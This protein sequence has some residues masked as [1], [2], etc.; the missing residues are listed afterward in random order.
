MSLLQYDSKDVKLKPSVEMEDLIKMAD[1]AAKKDI[2]RESRQY[3]EF[4]AIADIVRQKFRIARRH[5]ESEFVG[6]RSIETLLGQAEEQYHSIVPLAGGCETTEFATPDGVISVA[7][8]STA[9]LRQIEKFGQIDVKVS[10]TKDFVDVVTAMLYDSY[11]GESKVIEYFGTPVPTI[12]EKAREL[13]K[14]QMMQAI[15]VEE[16]LDSTQPFTDLV[17]MR[18]MA[19][20]KL[21][22]HMQEYADMVAE[23]HTLLTHDQMIEGGFMGEFSRFIFNFVLYPYAVM[24]GPIPE[25]A[26][27]VSWDGERLKT[28]YKPKMKF[29]NIHP[30]NYYWSPDTREAGTGEYDIIVDSISR[31]DLVKYSEMAKDNKGGFIKSAIDII[32]RETAEFRMSDG[33]S[34]KLPYADWFMAMEESSDKDTRYFDDTDRCTLVKFYGAFLGRDLWELGSD[35]FDEVRMEEYYEAEVWVCAGRTIWVG[36][37]VNKATR[38]RPIFAANYQEVQSGIAGYGLA[39]VLTDLERCRTMLLRAAMLHATYLAGP[40]GEYDFNRLDDTEDTVVTLEPLTLTPVRSDVGITT[41]SAVRFWSMPNNMVQLV[42][43]IGT[44]RNEAHTRTGISP[45]V[46]G[47]IQGS[48][49]RSY[50]GLTARLAQGMK[51]IKRSALALEQRVMVPMGR[52]MYWMNT[53]NAAEYEEYGELQGDCFPVVNGAVGQI[54]R[55]VAKS[56]ALEKLQVIGQVAPVL[57]NNVDYDTQRLLAD[58][59]LETIESLGIDINKYRRTEAEKLAEMQMQQAAI[60]QQAVAQQGQVGQGGQPTAQDIVNGVG[61]PGVEQGT[62]PAAML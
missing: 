54:E 18:E 39:A 41:G 11:M 47:E 42:N 2:K 16:K 43:M 61:V 56:E 13:I 51:I 60:A 7:S 23:N 30:R 28:T 10:I 40:M 21:L 44:L 37:A 15:M 49:D 32:L 22:D 12:P 20:D 19:K 14:E 45:S 57:Q 4:D 1:K 34:S 46:Y 55:E 52:Y 48:A 24:A 31:H 27:D 9:E 17:R 38:R 50:K 53:L 62:P 59:V 35:E 8:P 6:G 26:E 58:A 36:D 25:M 29:K 33:G 3:N 5:R